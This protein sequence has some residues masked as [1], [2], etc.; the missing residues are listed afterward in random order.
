MAP[1]H[2]EKSSIEAGK[3]AVWAE[4]NKFTT[5]GNALRDDYH[6]VPI[7]VETFGSWGPRGLKFVKEIGRK[8]QEKTGNKKATSHI[9]QAISMTVQRGN[10]TSIMGTLGPLR[11][12]EDFFDVISRR[13]LES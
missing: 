1:S 13:E 3:T 5:Y 9:I 12:L 4:E 11:K 6:F 2:V 8:I 7:A 10:A